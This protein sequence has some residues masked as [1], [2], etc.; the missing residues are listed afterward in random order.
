[1]KRMVMMMMM[2][3]VMIMMNIEMI[4]MRIFDGI[5]QLAS[6]TITDSDDILHK[7]LSFISL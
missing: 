7:K 3:I 6:I 1:M 2:M 4:S 5:F